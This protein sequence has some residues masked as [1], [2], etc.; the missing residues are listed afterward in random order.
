[1]VSSNSIPTPD[2]LIESFPTPTLPSIQG[3]P[4][5][6]PLAAI[7]S[8]LKA[9]TASI[10]SNKGGSANGYLGIIVSN[11]VYSTI[12]PGNPFVPPTNPTSNYPTRFH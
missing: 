5:Y 7:L 12:A 10:P 1:M 9:N 3:E 6:H 8:A 2:A 4:A 11:D